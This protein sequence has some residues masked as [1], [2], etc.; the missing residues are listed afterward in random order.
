MRQAIRSSVCRS[1][2]TCTEW[3]QEY[4]S[5]SVLLSLC[6]C[7]NFP[8]S[9]SVLPNSS[10]ILQTILARQQLPISL[11]NERLPLFKTKRCIW[12]LSFLSRYVRGYIQSVKLLISS[13][14]VCAG[15][16]T[17]SSI[18]DSTHNQCE[19][20]TQSHAG[21]TILQT[22][23]EDA[24]MTQFYWYVWGRVSFFLGGGGS[25]QVGMIRNSCLLN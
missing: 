23:P 10:E 22:T 24:D 12:R 16:Y 21:T 15:L 1:M 11:R 6:F 18:V 5:H 3:V 9:E 8:N 4:I 2:L 7:N 14:L 20:I 19:R 17:V 25:P 13:L